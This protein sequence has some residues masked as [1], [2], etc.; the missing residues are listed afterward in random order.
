M[1]S[2]NGIVAGVDVVYEVVSAVPQFCP[3]VVCPEIAIYE[4]KDSQETAFADDPLLKPYLRLNEAS[5][6]PQIE[7]R[8]TQLLKKLGL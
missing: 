4:E 1:M 8:V 6:G 5:D 2:A 7:T 3:A